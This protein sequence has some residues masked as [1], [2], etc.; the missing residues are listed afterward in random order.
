MLY[1]D[2]GG[3][4]AHYSRANPPDW[5]GLREDC[6]LWGR[7]KKV[8]KELKETLEMAWWYTLRCAGVPEKKITD[9]LGYGPS[10]EA[11]HT[12]FYYGETH[13]PGYTDRGYSV[14]VGYGDACVYW[15]GAVHEFTH[16]T[17]FLTGLRPPK[18]DPQWKACLEVHARLAEAAC[19]ATAYGMVYPR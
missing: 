18:P 19:L 10:G 17:H 1:V 11:A 8:W 4:V 3:G 12:L 2:A 14:W 5:G 6:R 9:T 15:C 7:S 13:F 16:V